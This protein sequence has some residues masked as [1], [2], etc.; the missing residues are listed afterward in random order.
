[1]QP[2]LFSLSIIRAE[3][4]DKA[5]FASVAGRS[6][7]PLRGKDEGEGGEVFAKD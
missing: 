4:L 6:C 2:R 3:L 7:S 1:M 5:A